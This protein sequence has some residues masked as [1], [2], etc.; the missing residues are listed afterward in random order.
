MPAPI[1]DK[2]IQ[3][4]IDKIVG[5]A[6]D[7]DAAVKSSDLNGARTNRDELIFTCLELIDDGYDNF[8]DEFFRG[9]ANANIAGDVAELSLAAVTG[10]TNG[11]RV[12]TILAIV[13]TAFKGARKS[14]DSNLFRE[15]STE[16][17][18]LKM[19][20]ARSRVR[21]DI[22]KGVKAPVNEYSLGAAIDDLVI[23]LHAGSVTSALLELAQDAGDDSKK[24][25]KASSDEKV[26]RY[27]TKEV[28]DQFKVIRTA[29]ETLRNRLVAD[30][31]KA[32][33]TVD[34]KSALKELYEPTELTGL[35]S[36]PAS[37]LFE[38]LQDK[39][40]ASRNDEALRK[41]VMKALK[42]SP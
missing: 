29:A 40:E 18:A 26:S 11:E 25:A 22:Y 19:R 8:E 15:R 21:T 41:K 4:R 5:L 2:L 12:K 32:Q 35:D 24:A 13:A 28:A 27:L 7:Y 23:Y 14:V 33:A 31:T 39:I 36:K 6:N 34:I 1:K 9:R 10:I 17:I 20:A 42:I 37:E 38:M 30:G 3:N 16:I